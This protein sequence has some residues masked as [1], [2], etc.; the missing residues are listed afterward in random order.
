MKSQ[1]IK[2][3]LCLFA[4]VIFVP[5]SFA[6]SRPSQVMAEM[7]VT[8]NHFPSVEQKKALGVIIK[9]ELSSSAEKTIATAILNLA[10]KPKPDDIAAL[11]KIA[12]DEK[13]T[14]EEKILASAVVG[15][16]H[17]A[18]EEAKEALQGIEK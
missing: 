4:F 7:L 8:I 2:S 3:L 15:F 10:H 16:N 11:N 6:D 5:F 12:A 14:D 17:R 9:S 1:P 13:A 18:S